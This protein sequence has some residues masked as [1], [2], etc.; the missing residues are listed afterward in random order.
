VDKKG[1]DKILDT[2]FSEK[3]WIR[4]GRFY[5]DIDLEGEPFE[6]YVTLRGR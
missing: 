5:Y 1:L 4:K 2:L 6:G 3:K